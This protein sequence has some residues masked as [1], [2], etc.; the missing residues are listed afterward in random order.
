MNFQVYRNLQELEPLSKAWNHLVEESASH[1]PFLRFESLS[2]WW[3]ALGGGEWETGDL[4]VVVARDE[5]GDL[6]GIAPLFFTRNL[7]NKPALM[8]LGSNSLSECSKICIS[9]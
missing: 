5:N 6:R 2:T 1:V 3:Q 4:N 7:D 9:S 8:F